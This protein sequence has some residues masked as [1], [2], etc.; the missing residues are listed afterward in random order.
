MVWE[1]IHNLSGVLDCPK[2]ATAGDRFSAMAGFSISPRATFC[3]GVFTLTNQSFCS[4]KVDFLDLSTLR[5]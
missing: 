5:A 4:G 1:D 3:K 2:A